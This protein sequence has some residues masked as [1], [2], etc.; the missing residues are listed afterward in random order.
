MVKKVVNVQELRD[1]ITCQSAADVYDYDYFRYV[2]SERPD[3]E[4]MGDNPY[5]IYINNNPVAWVN[6]GAWHE[7][8]VV[9]IQHCVFDHRV[10]VLQL[11]A[12]SFPY[13]VFG[14]RE[15]FPVK[16]AGMKYCSNTSTDGLQRYIFPTTFFTRDA[17]ENCIRNIYEREFVWGEG[18]SVEDI[19]FVDL[20]TDEINKKTQHFHDGI[21]WM[22]SAVNQNGHNVFP[23]F[24]YFQGGCDFSGNKGVRYLLAKSKSNNKVAGVI[25]YGHWPYSPNVTAIAYI[26]V[27]LG[28]RQKGVGTK[29]AKHFGT[30]IDVNEPLRLGRLSEMGQLCH[31]DEVFK[32]NLPADIS[33]D[34]SEY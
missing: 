28:A 4:L 14:C 12:D 23:G 2:Q 6:E 17:D 10:N 33:Y 22:P 11:L 34:E 25:R 30:I 24:H 20:S 5:L 16:E 3:K 32:R 21:F 26:D 8:K 29:L 15:S 13:A 1:Y 9:F 18:D 31:M 27:A 7:Q 19:E